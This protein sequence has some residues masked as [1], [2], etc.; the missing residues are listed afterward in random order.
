M[1]SAIDLEHLEGGATREAIRIEVVFT[2]DRQRGGFLEEFDQFGSAG[3][4]NEYGDETFEPRTGIGRRRSLLGSGLDVRTNEFHELLGVGWLG[5]KNVRVEVPRF[6]SGGIFRRAGQYDDSKLFQ[7]GIIS[8][9]VEELLAVYS[10][11]IQIE[12]NDIWPMNVGKFVA[13]VNEIERLLAVPRDVK[14]TLRV[15]KRFFDEPHITRIIL[16]Q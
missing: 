4:G 2:D 16:Y 15:L 7:I 11:Q 6:D 13:L 8:D 3:H 10:R 1:T 5:E 9:F 14:G 12:K